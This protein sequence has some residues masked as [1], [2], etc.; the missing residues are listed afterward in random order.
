MQPAIGFR[1]YFRNT[2]WYAK[3]LDTNKFIQVTLSCLYASF[4]FGFYANTLEFISYAVPIIASDQT[5]IERDN[6]PYIPTVLTG[7]NQLKGQCVF[8]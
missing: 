6:K 5:R 8:K 7:S 1:C 4:Q 2:L 3:L